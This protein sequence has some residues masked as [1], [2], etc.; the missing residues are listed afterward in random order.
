MDAALPT[1]TAARPWWPIGLA[2]AAVAGQLVA[3]YLPGSPS[4][5]VGLPGLD[6][7]VHLLLFAVPVWL[8]LRAGARFLLV[9]TGFA[10]H[11]A[12]SELVQHWAVSL[13]SGDPLDLAADLA[14]IG[15]AVAL[16]PRVA[17]Q[18]REQFAGVHLV[19]SAGEPAG[20]IGA[21]ALQVVDGSRVG[22]QVD[23]LGH[24]DD[25][26]AGIGPAGAGDEGVVRAQVAVDEPQGGHGP[27]RG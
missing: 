25:H 1:P 16:S 4:L 19:P 3:L 5:A 22:G 6:K 20:H 11:A 26:Q 17:K 12:V 14:G 23:Q 2:V 9:L 27:Q 18:V 7:V 21:V 13:R 24:V 15:L 10:C 8:F